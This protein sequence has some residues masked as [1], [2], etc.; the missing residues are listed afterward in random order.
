M[1]T[2]YD[3]D[4][5]IDRQGTNALK[6]DALQARYGNAGLLPLWIADM[7]FAT[8]PFITEALRA[9]MEHPIFGYTQDPPG[10]YP[11]IAK[12]LKDVHQWETKPDWLCYIPGVVKGIGMA[13]QVFT[14][15]G[16]KVIIQPPVYHLFRMVVEA[17]GRQAVNNPLKLVNGLYEMDFE[18]LER[19]FGESCKLFILCNPHNPGGTVW[20]R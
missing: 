12:W 6:V 10:Y 18:Q 5:V 1:Q 7:D 13:L 4:R 8:P 2:H 9:R 14:E 16:D 3:F 15:Q 11:A 20:S 17:N 19:I